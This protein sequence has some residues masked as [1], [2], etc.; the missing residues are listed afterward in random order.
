MM[1]NMFTILG[2]PFGRSFRRWWISLYEMAQSNLGAKQLHSD[3]AGVKGL[4]FYYNYYAVH[5]VHTQ[6]ASSNK[7]IMSLYMKQ[8]DAG[9]NGVDQYLLNLTSSEYDIH[10]LN[11]ARRRRIC[12]RQDENH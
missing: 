7:S 4:L 3:Q 1:Y 9:L 6:V 11:Q 10:V 8:I 2:P 12:T 5:V